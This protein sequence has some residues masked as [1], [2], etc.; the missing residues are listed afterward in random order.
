MKLIMNISLIVIINFVAFEAIAVEMAKD[1]II[2]GNLSV[3][4]IINPKGGKSEESLIVRSFTND[5]IPTDQDIKNGVFVGWH[6]IY[7]NSIIEIKN[8]MLPITENDCLQIYAS[9]CSKDYIKDYWGDRCNA[10]CLVGGPKAL[11]YDK[12]NKILYFFVAT[13]A[14][15]AAGGTDFVL[16]ANLI[17][18]KIK[19]LLPKFNSHQASL[20]P[21]GRYLLL[22]A[23]NSILI[24]DTKTGKK[25]NVEEQNNY[26]HDQEIYHYLMGIE[27]LSEDKFKYKHGIRHSKFQNSFDR[28]EI[29]EFDINAE[30]LN[31]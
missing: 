31:R 21:T 29:L 16:S 27:W 18:K 20:S 25:I 22:S 10:S 15:G 19:L 4:T 24:Y 1:E 11:T 13:T 30:E 8:N 7:T 3:K 26:P 23:Y 28:I 6:P 12:S 17:T 2:F 14:A 5:L 9:L